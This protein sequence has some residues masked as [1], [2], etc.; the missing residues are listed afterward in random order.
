MASNKNSKRYNKAMMESGLKS[1]EYINTNL[2]LIQKYVTDYAG[3][4][5]FWLNRLNNRQL[6]L[7]SDK[8]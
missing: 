4:Q 8:Y 6:D 3:R 2:G 1:N 5:D 7:L